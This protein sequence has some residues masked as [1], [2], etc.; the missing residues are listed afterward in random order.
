M[1]FQPIRPMLLHKADTPPERSAFIH[2]LKFDGH[3]A[4]FHFE[5][6]SRRLY[7]RHETDCTRSYAE[8]EQA[9]FAP[10]VRSCILDGEMIAFDQ[11]GKPSFEGVMERFHSRDARLATRHPVHFAAFDILFLNGESL[12]N[13]PLSHRLELLQDVVLPSDAMSVVKT[14]ASGADL[15]AYAEANGLEGCVSKRKDSRY[16]LDTRSEAW[17]KVKCYQYQTVIV[18][19]LRKGTFGWRMRDEDGRYLGIL[20]F[21]PSAARQAFRK[22]AGQIAVRE[23]DEWTYLQPAIRCKVKY[24]CLSRNGHLRSPSFVEFPSDG[25]ASD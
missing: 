20:E 6:G 11:D 2:Q 18:D 4:L 15:F 1:L 10:S 13:R 25:K 12:L 16:R 19:G 21:V 9:V 17:L 23:T 5:Q 7:T 3:R 24:Q 8:M 22:F 14:Y